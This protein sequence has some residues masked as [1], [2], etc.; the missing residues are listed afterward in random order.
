M[1][2][3]DLDL[4]GLKKQEKGEECIMRFLTIN[5]LNPYRVAVGCVGDVSVK[6]S[7]LIFGLSEKGQN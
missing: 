2:R 7:A 3:E 5:T 4:K 6:H 1:L